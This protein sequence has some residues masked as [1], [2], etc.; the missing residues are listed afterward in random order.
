MLPLIYTNA[1]ARNVTPVCAVRDRLGVGFELESGEVVRLA[2][3]RQNADALA[4]MLADYVKSPAGSQS[5]MS[6]EIPSEPRS[7][8]SEGVKV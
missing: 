2:I 3:S 5:P 1:Q 4:Q 6:Q 8:P 7:V